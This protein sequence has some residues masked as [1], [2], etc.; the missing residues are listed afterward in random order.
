[1]TGWSRLMGQTARWLNTISGVNKFYA[2]LSMEQLRS[3]V[4][5]AISKNSRDKQGTG[6]Q[7]GPQPSDEK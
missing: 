5:Q 2:E 7:E 3:E 1:M 4:D 6:Q